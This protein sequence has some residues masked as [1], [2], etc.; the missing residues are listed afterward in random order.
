M[1]TWSSSLTLLQK[2]LYMEV[3]VPLL[4][5]MAA[6]QGHEIERHQRHTSL[7]CGLKMACVIETGAVYHLPFLEVGISMINT[8]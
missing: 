5:D 1:G 2:L 8:R 7:Y 4:T 6:D 3:D